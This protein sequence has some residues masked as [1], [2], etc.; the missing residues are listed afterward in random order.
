VP[1]EAVH[2]LLGAATLCPRRRQQH[3]S[4]NP[5]LAESGKTTLFSLLTG[6]GSALAGVPRRDQAAVGM[7]GFRTRASTG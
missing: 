4:G 5:R 6:S 1:R 3:G 2:R 7:G